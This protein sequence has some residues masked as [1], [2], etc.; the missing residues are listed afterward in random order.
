MPA[1]LPTVLKEPLESGDLRFCLRAIIDAGESQ[2]VASGIDAGGD[3]GQI[4]I[5]VDRG[6]DAIERIAGVDGNNR[7]AATS[8]ERE[9]GVVGDLVRG[10]A[11]IGELRLRGRAG[12]RS[13]DG[14]PLRTTRL[15]T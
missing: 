6:G 3:A 14:L 10:V 2:R 15:C 8:P 1:V 9:D 12:D 5:I 4:A 13:G 7:A 11:R